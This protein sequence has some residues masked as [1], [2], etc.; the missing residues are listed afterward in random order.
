MN[1]RVLAPPRLRNLRASGFTL[2]ELMIT[3]SIVAILAAIAYPSY[4]NYVLRGQLVSATNGLT[5]LQANMERFYQDNRQYTDSGTA[6]SPCDATTTISNFTLTCTAV[7]AP[8]TQTF[9]L[10][11]NGTGMMAGFQYTLDNTSNQQTSITA[12]APGGWIIT[13][14]STWSTRAG[15]C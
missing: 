14:P 15:Q 5:A 2:I 3:V 9:M 7:N 11:A 13:C 12:P 6:V 10:S 1:K 8:P 4:R